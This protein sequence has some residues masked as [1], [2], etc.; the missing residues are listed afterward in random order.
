MR[1]TG[2]SES[3]GDRGRSTKTGGRC[4]R[5]SLSSRTRRT[6]TKATNS[7]PSFPATPRHPVEGSRRR[8][9]LLEPEGSELRVVKHPR[10]AVLPMEGELT[11]GELY[12]LR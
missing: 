12:V 10:I 7:S 9:E 8:A 2:G 1:G 11:N 5:S 3:Q 4:T 6:L